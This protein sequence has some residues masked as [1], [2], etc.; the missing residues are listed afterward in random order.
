V[1]GVSPSTATALAPIAPV[2]PAPAQEHYVIDAHGCWVWQRAA[3]G[4]GYALE[5]RGSRRRAAARMYFEREHGP[6]PTG[7]LLEHRCGNRR[8]VNPEHQRLCTRE[9]LSRRSSARRLTP[10]LVGELRE[11]HG[12]GASTH[13]LAASLGLNYWTV[14]D[15]LTGRTWAGVRPQPI[16]RTPDPQEQSR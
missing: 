15:A 9:D 14:A 5:R 4:A 13:T 2:T 10:A 11:R 1:D 12:T 7:L 6:I 3:N 8:C 16:R